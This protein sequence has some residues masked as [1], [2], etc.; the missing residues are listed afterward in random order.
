MSFCLLTWNVLGGWWRSPCSW[1][2][3]LKHT[4]KLFRHTLSL[5]ATDLFRSWYIV[6]VGP[7]HDPISYVPV[8]KLFRFYDPAS[9]A[10]YETTRATLTVF[11]GYSMVPGL[12]LCWHIDPR[13]AIV[14]ILLLLTTFGIGLKCFSDFGKGLYESKTSG[15]LI[16]SCLFL[17]LS[18]PPLTC[19]S[20]VSQIPSFNQGRRRS[21]MKL[22]RSP[23]PLV[24]HCSRDCRSSNGQSYPITFSTL[25]ST[26][27]GAVS[28]LHARASPRHHLMRWTF[29]YGC[30]CSKVEAEICYPSLW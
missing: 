23:N 28:R 30:C 5:A 4:V 12:S 25:I 18:V 9:E 27:S 16:P 26:M 1:C 22:E 11:S 21:L 10:Q 8:Y 3:H 17:F 14:S 7:V 29:D 20:H 6:F 13:K 24:T 15:Q 19:D 2:W